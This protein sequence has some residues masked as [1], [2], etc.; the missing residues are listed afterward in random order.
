[1]NIVTGS[2]VKGVKSIV[3]ISVMLTA[4]EIEVIKKWHKFYNERG[5]GSMYDAKFEQQLI[6]RI[7]SMVPPDI[8][9]YM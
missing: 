5:C 6:D 3:E 4:Y 9:I 7:E 2:K 8:E 1:M